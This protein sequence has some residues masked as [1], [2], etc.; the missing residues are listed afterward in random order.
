MP[1]STDLVVPAQ[2]TER[3][4]LSSTWA[5]GLAQHVMPLVAML[6]DLDL[7]GRRLLAEPMSLLAEA[8]SLRREIRTI[9]R[10]ADARAAS[11]RTDFEAGRIDLE[12]LD[13]ACSLADRLKNSQSSTSVALRGALAAR[14]GRTENAL[15][16]C[17]PA[18]WQAMV[19]AAEGY[20]AQATELA[21][22]LPEDLSSGNGRADRNLRHVW[23]E[24]DA[25]AM[26]LHD[27]HH[28]RGQLGSWS[29]LSL[30][31]PT[32][33]AYDLL[34]NVTASVHLWL[35]HTQPEKLPSDYLDYDPPARLVVAIRAGSKPGLIDP[36]DATRAFTEWA[37]GLSHLSRMRSPDRQF[38]EWT[39]AQYAIP[40]VLGDVM[41]R[42]VPMAYDDRE[43]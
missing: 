30:F 1:V 40:G 15:M 5:S 21:P 39:A 3:E 19:D 24:L 32:V 31:A 27:L 12:E 26:R 25:A 41:G 4:A 14:L 34:G 35:F 11:A 18:L 6:D 13:A 16:A 22:K 29:L 28:V 37:R 8:S 20:V 10:T 33:H 38:D 23:A 43:V 9:H 36:D 42:L 7:D 2:P 17:V